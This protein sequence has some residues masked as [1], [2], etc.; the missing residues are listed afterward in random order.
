MLIGKP[1]WK[2][3]ADDILARLEKANVLVA[4]N[5]AFDGAFIASELIGAD[6]H[7]PLTPSYCTMENGRWATFNGKLPKLAELCFALGVDYD[8]QAAHAADYDTDVTAQCLFK[9]IDRGFFQLPPY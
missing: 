9:G 3:V 6:K 2:D 5:F 4:H 1:K 8:P 7:V